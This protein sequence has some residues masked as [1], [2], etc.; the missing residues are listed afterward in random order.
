MRPLDE[1][2]N[3]AILEMVSTYL[4]GGFDTTGE[5]MDSFDTLKTLYRNHGKITVNTGYSDQTIFGAPEV[6]WA[7]RA[8]HDYCHLTGNFPFTAF[9]EWCASYMQIQQLRYHYPSHPQLERWCRLVDIEVNGQVGYY[10][11]HKQ[12]PSNQIQFTLERLHND[13]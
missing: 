13:I 9:G 2:F 6:N 4:P 10:L 8:W 3:R 5:E 1:G 7:F 12:F 11:K